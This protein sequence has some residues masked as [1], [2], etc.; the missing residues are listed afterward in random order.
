MMWINDTV[1]ILDPLFRRG[2]WPLFLPHRVA[3]VTS[4][5]TTQHRT[6]LTVLAAVVPVF[7][8]FDKKRLQ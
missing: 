5:V 8:V 3:I 6:P 7:V 4:A 1:P 2:C